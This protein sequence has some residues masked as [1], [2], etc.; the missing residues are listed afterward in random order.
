[1]RKSFIFRR[2]CVIAMVLAICL[3]SWQGQS[4][5]TA[6]AAD[7]GAEAL[8]KPDDITA[9]VTLDDQ[10]PAEGKFTF[11]LLDENNTVLEEVKNDANGNIKFTKKFLAKLDG[12]YQ[13]RQ[14]KDETV[15]DIEYGEDSKALKIK[16]EEET[17]PGDE[18]KFDNAIKFVGNAD[19]HGRITVDYWI[20]GEA[21][22]HQ[23]G[24]YCINTDIKLEDN[25]KFEAIKDPTTEQL[26][27][28]IVKKFYDAESE[29]INKGN[30]FVKH[31]YEKNTDSVIDE[32][33]Y[34]YGEDPAKVLKK[35]LYY[36]EKI[37]LDADYTPSGIHNGNDYKQN[38]VWAACGG[39]WGTKRQYVYK[40]HGEDGEITS[41]S[42]PQKAFDYIKNEN[43]IS[44]IKDENIKNYHVIIFVS[45]GNQ[46]QPVAFGYETVYNADRKVKKTVIEPIEFKNKTK[47]KQ[48]VPN[49]VPIQSNEIPEEPKEVP[50][51]PEEVKE[52]PKETP[53]KPEEV[54]EEPKETPE[55]PEEVKEEPKETPEKPEE[56]KEEPKETPKK[57][58]EVK[59]EP[60][61][62]DKTVEKDF[63]EESEGENVSET[64][65]RE[66]PEPE[67]VPE[68]TEPNRENSIPQYP[69]NAMPD[70]NDPNSPDEFIAVNADGTPQG[71]YIKKTL[72]DGSKEYVLVDDDGVPRGVATLP[73]TG[74]RDSMAY[75]MG[76]TVLLV[77]AG[78]VIRKKYD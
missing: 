5:I 31:S 58:E 50:Q 12:K 38:A 6:E 45:D 40:K 26:A 14:K 19:E 16:V 68:V 47:N 4:W 66:T 29:V 8:V 69:V 73:R 20:N 44:Q 74:A 32:I 55:K 75:Y 71:K 27:Q 7:T 10:T 60:K 34:M 76:G 43:K 15:S 64:D 17:V 22:K 41:N 9:K 11:E 36:L 37:P 57:P 54:K 70:A 48:G 35:T 1:M 39:T 30:I 67:E 78:F 77:L 62:T 18:G 46:S 53:K 61:Q 28:Y 49:I 25:T 63:E 23:T 3:V 59:K 24:A 21:E 2:I 65:P 51:K 72:P 13:I 52:E 56:V 42:L 33:Q